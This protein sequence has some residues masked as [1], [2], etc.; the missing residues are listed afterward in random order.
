M[1]RRTDIDWDPIKRDY[2]ADLLTGDELATR[3]GVDRTSIFRRAKKEGWTKNLQ[4]RVTER[5]QAKLVT[6]A[7]PVG[8]QQRNTN[9]TPEA[10]KPAEAK[11]SRAKASGQPARSTED[12]AV[13]VAATANVQV[14][15][16]H[17]TDI[18]RARRITDRLWA[19]AEAQFDDVAKILPMLAGADITVGDKKLGPADL[20]RIQTAIARARDLPTRTATVKGLTEAMR[21]QQ[22]L[23]RQA[24]GIDKADGGGDS[25]T[26]DFRQRLINARERALAARS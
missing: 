17:R 23:E 2:E 13:E 7:A 19:E 6:A 4:A 3:H 18:T 11:P 22:A 9:A 15:L 24:F 16:G 10:P 26:T 1:A 20:L 8:T 21:L 14:I 25:D 5:T 12:E